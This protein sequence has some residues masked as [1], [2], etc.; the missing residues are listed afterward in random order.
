[1]SNERVLKIVRKYHP[2]V[3]HVRDAKYPAMVKLTPQDCAESK[4]KAP[5]K[6]ALAHAFTKRHDG[7]IISMAVAYLIDGNTATRY[8]VP[9]S[10][11]REIISFDRGQY[12]APG[13][14]KL[15]APKSTS[16]LGVVRKGKKSTSRAGGSVR[17]IH[18]TEGIRT[19]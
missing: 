2:N 10:I 19:L 9:S 18:K 15:L 16:R 14:Y 4:V 5:D 7:A 8:R 13:I 3:T 17:R 12:F 11:S 1:M 6:C